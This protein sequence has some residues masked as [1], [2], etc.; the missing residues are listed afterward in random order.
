[1]RKPIH[2][3]DARLGVSPRQAVN[4]HHPVYAYLEGRID[5]HMEGIGAAGEDVI[6]T[7]ADNNRVAV[8][9]YVLDGC[10]GHLR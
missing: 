4:P 6:P 5:K 3:D 7:P 10:L 1:V 2:S 8:L 9:G